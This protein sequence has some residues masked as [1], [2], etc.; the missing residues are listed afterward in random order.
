MAMTNAER[1]RAYRARKRVAQ[2]RAPRP[3]RKRPAAKSGPTDQE[4]QARAEAAVS[5][6]MAW[7]AILA[8]RTLAD[9]A[10]ADRA[11]LGDEEVKA[12]RIVFDAHTKIHG[13]GAAGTAKARVPAPAPV[14]APGNAR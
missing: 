9:A 10:R 8:E 2:G 6:G 4:L 13:G 11:T 5:R 7:A 12:A 1:Q 3:A 14:P